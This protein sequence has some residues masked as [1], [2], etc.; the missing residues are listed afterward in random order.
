MYGS[1]D[2]LIELFSNRFEPDGDGYVFRANLRAEGI[3]VSKAERDK[4]VADYSRRIKISMWA[5]MGLMTALLI[6]GVVFVVSHDVDVPQYALYV[7]FTPFI[8]V[9]V[10]AM[11][12]LAKAPTDTS[13]K[14]VK[15]T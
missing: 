8:L 11:L 2:R 10:G 6:G 3:P 9:S 7:A 4:F 13:M 12:W 1:F 14:G 15:A 5:S